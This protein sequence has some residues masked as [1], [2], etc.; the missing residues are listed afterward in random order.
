MAQLFVGVWPSAAAVQ[1]L[2][3]YPKPG[4]GWVDEGQW[5]VNVRPLGH[6]TDAVAAALLDVLRF[7]LDGMPP[8]KA[9]FGAVK[10]RGCVR[11]S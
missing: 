4:D 10:A 3:A 1:A 9:S 7:E 8:P 5:L 2:R 6:V 11:W